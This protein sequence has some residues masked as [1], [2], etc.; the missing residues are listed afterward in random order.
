M[1]LGDI[2]FIEGTRNGTPIDAAYAA[3]EPPCLIWAITLQLFACIN[4][5]NFLYFSIK[6]LVARDNSSG[7]ACP[8]GLLIPTEPRII[9]AHPPWALAR[10]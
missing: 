1:S 7:V 10:K 2:S 4:F 9:P 5:T 3:F 6:L 8:A